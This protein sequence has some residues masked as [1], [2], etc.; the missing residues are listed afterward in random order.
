MRPSTLIGVA[1]LGVAAWLLLA[2]RV[3]ASGLPGGGVG[4]TAPGSTPEGQ[5]GP[6][7]LQKILGLSVGTAT[8]LARLGL[9]SGGTAAAAGG[10]TAA[11]AGATSGGGSTLGNTGAFLA[12]NPVGWAILGGVGGVM[13]WQ[14]IDENHNDHRDYLNETLDPLGQTL[15][16]APGYETWAANNQ[17]GLFW[18]MHVLVGIEGSGANDKYYGTIAH[19]KTDDDLR[20]NV[21]AIDRVLAG[22]ATGQ[23][24]VVDPRSRAWADTTLVAMAQSEH[25]WVREQLQA[26]TGS[27]AS[28]AA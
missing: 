20:R 8:T 11:A 10:G 15:A 16:G 21:Q 9:L 23:I 28:K 26:A 6:S 1:A 3:S 14:A 7:K 5:P 12:T 25:D 27:L 2:R 13:V 18:L 22:A 19:V 24:A 17:V 4:L